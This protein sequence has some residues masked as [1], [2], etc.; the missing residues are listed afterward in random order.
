MCR[1]RGN[2]RQKEQA[3]VTLEYLLATAVFAVLASMSW[4]FYQAYVVGNLYGASDGTQ[5]GAFGLA[6]EHYAWGLERVVSQPFP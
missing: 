1:K 3:Q 6:K 4:M 5:Y 2:L